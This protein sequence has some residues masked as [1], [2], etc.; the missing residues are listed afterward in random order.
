MQ[1]ETLAS[2]PHYEV[3]DGLRGIAAIAVVIFHCYEI[4]T[5]DLTQSPIAHGFLA[6]DFFFCL[7]GF[8]IAYAYD[9]RIHQIGV[10]RF[11]V[12]RLIRLQPLV[13]LGT[14]LGLA[15]L[16]LDPF[17]TSPVQ[18]FGWGKIIIATVCSVLMLPCPILGRYENVFPLNAPAWSLSM[19]YFI[20][21]VYAFVLV[22]ITKK[23]LLVFLAIAIAFIVWT[24]WHRGNLLGGWNDITFADGYAR[25]LFSFIAGL[26]VY[27]FR[28]TIKNKLHFVFYTIL[29]AVV[30]LFPH[31]E[32]DW[33]TEI[34]FVVVLFPLLV[35]GGAG[36]HVSGWVKKICTFLG[37]I[38][39]PLYMTHYWMIW[40]LGNY[41]AT[42]PGERNLYLFSGVIFITTIV[43]AWA[44]LR[45]F[46]EPVRKWLTMKVKGKISNQQS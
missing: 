26:V 18:E 36:T 41:A 43:L 17:T 2:K 23:L 12:N 1:Q 27:R 21:L 15:G 24:G 39:Y 10:K 44:S 7:S 35:A 28:L 22:R 8:V 29:L 42:S 32:N 16:F 46:D 45:F 25:V 38:S 6:V 20:N 5:P 19:E 40:I 9:S 34:L 30:F 13:L 3:L 11:F 31:F 14:A 4:L 37:D 33:L